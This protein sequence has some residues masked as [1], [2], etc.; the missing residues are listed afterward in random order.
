VRKARKKS[1]KPIKFRMPF[2]TAVRKRVKASHDLDDGH[3]DPNQT[4]WQQ[5]Q[6]FLLYRTPPANQYIRFTFRTGS[7]GQWRFIVWTGDDSMP[8]TFVCQVE[9]GSFQGVNWPG[10]SLWFG[11]QDCENGVWTDWHLSS[12]DDEGS[13]EDTLFLSITSLTPDAS[14]Y[15]SVAIIQW[16]PGLASPA[17][18][19]DDPVYTFT[20][21]DIQINNTRSNHEDT[22]YASFVVNTPL[23][24]VER[25]P[26]LSMGDL[27]SGPAVPVNLSIPNVVV[28]QNANVSIVWTVVNSG[29][30]D[31]SQLQKAIDQTLDAAIQQASKPSSDDDDGNS[32]DGAELLTLFKDL[33]DSAFGFAFADC[34]GPVV[35]GHKT[36][37]GAALFN[38]TSP[39]PLV[40]SLT[41]IGDDWKQSPAGCRNSNYNSHVVV[42]KTQ[43]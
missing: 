4:D 23:H 15:G 19:N 33:F 1:A 34:D 24:G 39:S 43:N 12:S 9:A 30:Q 3:C 20:F 28:P 31:V 21:K 35:G 6:P 36:L 27:N 7:S 29:H 22:N 8:D 42:T 14:G 13:T 41:N 38:A 37:S 11:I 40:I 32:S 2:R 25:T 5:F 16:A 26:T 10:G 18:P 17:G